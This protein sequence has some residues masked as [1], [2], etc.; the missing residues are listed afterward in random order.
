[1]ILKILTGFLMALA[2]SVPGVSGGTIAFLM[3]VYDEFIDSLHNIFVG[4]KH[5][6][7]KALKFLL[8]LGCGWIVGIVLA[9]FVLTKF[10]ESNINQVSL[11]L[12]GFILFSLPVF[13]KEEWS[14][15][16]NKYYN[17]LFTALG[18]V[19]VVCITYFNV[20]SGGVLADTQNLNVQNVLYIFLVGMLAIS[21][22]V[23]PGISGSSIL[24]IFGL[25]MPI[26]SALREAMHLNP[27]AFPVCIIF[28]LGII[29]G[30]I[31]TIKLI[32]FCL[33]KFRSQTLYMVIGMML[34][35]IYSIIVG[36]V[37]L[38]P[39]KEMITT[40][41]FSILFFL[42]GGIIIIGLQVLKNILQKRKLNG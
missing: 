31:V 3:G 32:R 18:G 13:I 8:K 22:M 36:P 24:M 15:I 2:D 34:G 25:Y 29:A 39:A 4:K 1:M 21:A 41:N 37:T 5:E 42:L 16:K 40:T 30:V 23:L 28:G 14:S 20:S 35:S 26:M 19:L 9:V 27:S 7:L 6:R 38:V 17:L 12:L 10:F 11:L 33:K